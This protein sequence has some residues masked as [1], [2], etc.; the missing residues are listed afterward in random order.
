M[1]ALPMNIAFNA[2]FRDRYTQKKNHKAETYKNLVCICH[3][4]FNGWREYYLDNKF[5]FY[6][7]RT[8]PS[9]PQGVLSHLYQKAFK[10]T[11]ECLFHAA[12]YYYLFYLYVGE[13]VVRRSKCPPCY[14]KS[15]PPT[16]LWK[17]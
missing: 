10:S 12:A 8:K 5:R 3:T 7:C 1:S 2:E 16:F 9:T 15:Y 13:E 14:R 4:K 11:S 17:T 6:Y